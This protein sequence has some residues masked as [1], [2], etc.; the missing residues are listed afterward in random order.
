MEINEY[1]TRAG[2]RC[3]W[4]KNIIHCRTGRGRPVWPDSTPTTNGIWIKCRKHIMILKLSESR[5]KFYKHLFELNPNFY[6]SH[7]QV[8]PRIL[9]RL[10]MFIIVFST[11]SDILVRFFFECVPWITNNCKSFCLKLNNIFFY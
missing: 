11:S 5:P 3:L 1:K 8:E 9:Y 4:R 2:S 10:L 7:I 6:Y